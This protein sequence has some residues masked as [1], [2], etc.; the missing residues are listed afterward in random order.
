MAD[1][2]IYKAV[3]AWRTLAN[4]VV[5]LTKATESTL[6]TYRV[7]VTPS[8]MHDVGAGTVEA[9]FYF[10]SY[11]GNPYLIIDTGTG[12]IDVEDSFRFRKCPT[13]GKNGI[14]YKSVGNGDSPY[15]APFFRFLHPNAFQ[16]FMG[17]ALDILWR[18]SGGA[19][20]IL[21]DLAS[22]SV[23]VVFDYPF[24]RTP[25]GRK[26]LHVYRVTTEYGFAIDTQVLF[27]SLVVNNE[28]F[29]LTIDDSEA[30]TGIIIEY[31]FTP[32]ITLAV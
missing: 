16:K 9:G 15:L 19:T 21:T 29:T 18:N 13:S 20:G 3:C 12:Y 10:I 27:H 7:Y 4:K 26:H 32:Q 2:T 1:A 6:A 14:V 17:I 23:E 24:K 5:Q 30:L 11:M 22:R 25:V 31:H 8:D 28:G